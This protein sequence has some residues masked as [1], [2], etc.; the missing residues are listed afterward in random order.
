MLVDLS[1]GTTATFRVTHAE[2]VPQAQFPT[3]V[4][5]GP[6]PDAQ[7][8]LITCHTFDRAAGRYTQNLVVF[9]TLA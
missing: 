9:A 5:Y 6:V 3:E 8:R 7:L 4:V 1:D 2:V